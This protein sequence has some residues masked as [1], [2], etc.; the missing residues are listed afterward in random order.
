[1]CCVISLFCWSEQLYSSLFRCG[2]TSTVRRTG[3][4]LKSRINRVFDV[5]YIVS[6]RKCICTFLPGTVLKIWAGKQGG[7]VVTSR[8][9]FPWHSC[10]FHRQ[11]TSYRCRF[12]YRYLFCFH[13]CSGKWRKYARRLWSAYFFWSN[14]SEEFF[15]GLIAKIPGRCYINSGILSAAKWFQIS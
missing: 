7:R 15:I 6:G 11:R 14:A 1:M 4:L 12:L 9:S 5:K 10:S 2:F 8:S 3:K 13:L